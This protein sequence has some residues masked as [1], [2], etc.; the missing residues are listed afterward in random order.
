VNATL[1]SSEFTFDPAAVG[2]CPGAPCNGDVNTATTLTFFGGPLASS[3]GILINGG[4]PLGAPLPLNA[5]IFN[6]FLQFAGHANL[7]FILTGVNAG[8]TNTNC[9]GLANG[10]SCSLNENGTP[11][12]VV[13][14]LS[15]TTNTNVSLSLFGTATDGIG[16][17]SLWVGGFSAT[18]PNQTPAQIAQLFCGADGSCTAAEVLASPNLVVRS[19]SGSFFSFENP[20]PEP[21]TTVLMG[22]GLILLGLTLRRF[23]VV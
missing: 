19:V 10:E 5:Q 7:K 8:S 18:I 17:S 23:R 15:G 16:L 3:E 9:F 11:S 4:F 6:P 20:V 12:N 1:T 22:A 14:T 21:S 13:L 2:I